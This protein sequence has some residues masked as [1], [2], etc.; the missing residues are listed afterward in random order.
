MRR[1]GLSVRFVAYSLSAASKQREIIKAT[2]E[3][4]QETERARREKRKK[5][6]VMAVECAHTPS[7]ATG[8]PDAT[9]T[10]LE[11]RA[12]HTQQETQRDGVIETDLEEEVGVWSVEDEDACL[13]PR[14]SPASPRITREVPART[15]SNRSGELG[16]MEAAVSGWQRWEAGDDLLLS[17]CCMT[18]EQQSERERE[19]ERE[20]ESSAAGRED[21]LFAGFAHR[22]KD[23]L[24]KRRIQ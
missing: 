21:G 16:K 12:T 11:F 20:R 10:S 9:T 1:K 15:V 13:Q 23:S 22:R 3:H 17:V 14:I 2:N 8:A 6:R 7:S 5:D 24:D 18:N 19:R 4:G